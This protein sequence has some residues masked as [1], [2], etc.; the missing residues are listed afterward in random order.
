MLITEPYKQE[1]QLYNELPIKDKW[2]L[3]KLHVAE[4]MG[5]NCGPSGTFPKLHGTY[6]LRPVHN[7]RG[8]FNTSFYK[9][10]YTGEGTDILKEGFFWC[11]W[12]EGERSWTEY[13]NDVGVRAR[14]GIEDENGIL[15]CADGIPIPL[16]EQV[17]GIS[18]YLLVERIDGKVI[19]VAPR[20]M[21]SSAQQNMIDDYRTI[22]PSYNP[23]DIT[24][25]DGMTSKLISLP[26]GEFRWEE[27]KTL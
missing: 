7:V 5:H 9:I 12:F 8:M 25:R 18:R 20:L 10:E 4:A 23:D 27:V 26:G 16:E 11:Q 1:Y 6:C 21:A 3:N 14:V 24:M 13:V 19:E 2:I 22:D 15:E 17:K